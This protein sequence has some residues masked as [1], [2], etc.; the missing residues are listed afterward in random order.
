MRLLNISF[1]FLL[2]PTAL[3]A[4]N[5]RTA[6]AVL[7]ALSIDRILGIME[8]ESLEAGEELARDVIAPIAMS[9][10]QKTIAEINDPDRLEAMMR[11]DFADTLPAEQIT[12]IL[13]FIA[14]DQGQRYVQLEISAREALLDPEIE[15]FSLDVLDQYRADDEPRLRM[16]RRFA[17]VNDLVDANVVGALNANAAFLRGMNAGVENGAVVPMSD[18]EIVAQVW[19]QEEE[20]RHSTEEWVFSFL[21]LAYQPLSDSE[22]EVYIAF[23][24]SEAGQALNQALFEAFDAIFVLTA[25]QTGE[26][27]ASALASEDI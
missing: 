26:A 5:V 9:S 12:P 14:S 22:L 16:V 4:Q 10:W 2:L 17:T 27:M 20:I 6:D 13:D 15:E 25:E 23:S 21:L 8:V 1:L 11:S 18:A 3:F 24:E 19:A 7:D